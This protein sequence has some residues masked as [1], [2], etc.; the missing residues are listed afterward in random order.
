MSDMFPE[1]IPDFTYK[2]VCNYSYSNDELLS[3]EDEISLFMM[4]NKVQ[5]AED[6]S[7]F[8]R[9]DDS[10]LNKILRRSPEHTLKIIADAMWSLCM[11]LN[12]PQDEAVDCVGRVW[13]RD[14]GYLFENIEK[15]DIQEERR[16][17]KEAREEL[18]EAK[19]RANEAEEALE[20]ALK[21]IQELELKLSDK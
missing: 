15:M 21:R 9:L 3:R 12:V 6:M 10:K 1:Y 19:Y 16:K 4:L 14:M 20:V 17:L 8:L 13:N 2:L 5:T 11:K 18:E 7:A